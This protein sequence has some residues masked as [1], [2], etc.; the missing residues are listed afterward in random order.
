MPLARSLPGELGAVLANCSVPYSGAVEEDGGFVGPAGFDVGDERNLV[1]AGL[2]REAIKHA[3]A[4]GDDEY[5]V[6]TDLA[7]RTGAAQLG[8]GTLR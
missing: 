2:A 8:A 5:A 3:F 1:A 4:W 7:D 6:A